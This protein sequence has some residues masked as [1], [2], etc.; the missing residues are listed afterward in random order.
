MFIIERY[1]GNEKFF[2]SW[3]RWEVGNVG[4]CIRE[5][6]EMNVE[7]LKEKEVWGISWQREVFKYPL[8]W[9]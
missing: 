3:K 7:L 8:R 9:Q 6:R 2:E 5:I 1:S 4:C